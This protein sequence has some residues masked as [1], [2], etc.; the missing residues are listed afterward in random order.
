MGDAHTVSQARDRSEVANNQ[1][2]IL[3]R[4]TL[5]QQ[6][7]CAREAVIGVNP[8]EPGGISVE[9]VHGWLAAVEAVQLLD[10]RLYSPMNRILHYVPFEA[11]V[12]RP[13]TN[14]AEFSSHEEEFLARLGIHIAE[15]QTQIGKLLPFVARHFSDERSLTV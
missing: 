6:G 12:V 15:Q 13:F 14:L 8:F 9:H 5:A 3:R 10:P 2:R 7:N 1:D 11:G 4:L